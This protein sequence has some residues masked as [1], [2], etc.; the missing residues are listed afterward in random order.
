M[1]ILVC[2][3]RNFSDRDLVFD[4]LYK[5]APERPP[6]EYGNTLPDCTI[7][8]G[9]AKGA[10]SIADE[11][12]V[13]NW[14][15]L[16]IY[17]ADWNT[18]GKAAGAIRNRRMLRDGKPDVVVAFPGGRGTADMVKI[19]QAAGIKVIFPASGNY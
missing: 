18:H 11:W 7:I 19:A 10:D 8:H 17:K 2:G 12:A 1:R 5:I 13:V 15:G 16:E 3:G 9:G 4:A 6:D 14:T